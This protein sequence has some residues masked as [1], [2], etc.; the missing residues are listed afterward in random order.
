MQQNALRAIALMDWLEQYGGNKKFLQFKSER[1]AAFQIFH[2]ICYIGYKGDILA[3]P[4]NISSNLRCSSN[5]QT[6]H[7]F[8]AIQTV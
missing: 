4:L 7:C 2:L 1:G 8:L 3:H 6:P 5:I